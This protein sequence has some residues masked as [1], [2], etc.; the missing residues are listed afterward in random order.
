MKGKVLEL[1][2]TLYC[3]E[4]LRHDCH[5]FNSKICFNVN[6][7]L[8]KNDWDMAYLKSFSGSY[9]VH[10][11]GTSVTSKLGQ[12]VCTSTLLHLFS[13][14]LLL[15]CFLDLYRQSSFLLFFQ[16]FCL[17]PCYFSNLLNLKGCEEIVF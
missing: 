1:Q 8:W 12:S 14:L 10:A 11:N 7:Y 16:L 2:V 17:F 15:Q 9:G 4:Y 6:F 3:V 5:H 13:T